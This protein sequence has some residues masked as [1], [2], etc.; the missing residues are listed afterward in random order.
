VKT[1]DANK[2]LGKDDLLITWNRTPRNRTI[3]DLSEWRK[4]PDSIV[5]RQVKVH[6]DIPGYRPKDFYIVTTLI[7]P[8][9]Y[10][11]EDIKEIYLKRWNVELYFRDLKTTLGMD[12]L[13]CKSPDMVEKEILMNFI[14][15][16]M[17]KRLSY[18][19][20]KESDSDPDDVSFKSCQQVLLGYVSIN[21][22]KTKVNLLPKMLKIIGENLILKRPQ[23]VEP[24]VVKRRPKPF[25]LMMKPRSELK[26]DL[27]R[28]SHPKMA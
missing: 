3:S 23:R 20:I 25:K 4:L 26:L 28:E 24:R 16:N 5:L 6:I 18:D 7:D 15:F 8:V 12:I 13:R 17:L 27:V 14:V 21:E 2:I 10:P 19:S 1:Q 22:D 11:A 9:K